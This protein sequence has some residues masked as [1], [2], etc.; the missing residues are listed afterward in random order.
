MVI[1]AQCGLTATAADRCDGHGEAQ[2]ADGSL[3]RVI[4]S[5]ST[6]GNYTPWYAR[7]MSE[8]GSGRGH[9]VAEAQF[10][11]KATQLGSATAL[12]VGVYTDLRAITTFT[13]ADLFVDISG[14]AEWRAHDDDLTLRSAWKAALNGNYV[15]VG[16]SQ[17]SPGDNQRCESPTCKITED[18]LLRAFMQARNLSVSVRTSLS[19][20]LLQQTITLPETHDLL[21]L[22]A[23]ALSAAK[24]NSED[25][26]S[27]PSTAIPPPIAILSSIPE[28]QYL[29][30]FG[31]E[32]SV[33]FL[34]SDHSRKFGHVA[35][36]KI[37]TVYNPPYRVDAT[38]SAIQVTTDVVFNCKTQSQ[39]ILG[40]DAY[41]ESGRAVA[42]F[43]EQSIG[44][45]APGSL[46]AL[47]ESS[48][49]EQEK[50]GL[51]STVNGHFA[52]LEKARTE[53][54]SK[55]PRP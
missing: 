20:M 16:N 17:S 14:A 43:R 35:Q 47:A 29:R 22:Y 18:G 23:Q 12:S 41:D 38:K 53:L 28:G 13:T 1:I 21:D 40:G 48:V 32:K 7:W 37:F 4:V 26:K 33:S 8:A 52:A 24:K 39:K 2:G 50:P 19:E 46:L 55:L 42:A 6:A 51:A 44:P 25:T 36:A 49:C 31:T 45:I 5:P 9:I 34:I 15:V 30:I 3:F 10:Q 11:P 27:C 54:E